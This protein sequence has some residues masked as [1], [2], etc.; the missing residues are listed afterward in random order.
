MMAPSTTTVKK[1]CLTF[2]GI[3]QLTMISTLDWHDLNRTGIRPGGTYSTQPQF[4]A[5]YT[6]IKCK[7]IFSKGRFEQ[8]LEGRLL[9]EYEKNSTATD[10][11]R[12]TAVNNPGTA[13]GTRASITAE[14]INNGMG[15]SKRIA[16]TTI[17]CNC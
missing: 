2:P 13:N 17:R 7:N 15:R 10:A 5:T 1:L 8:D 3:N 14:D 16:G 12:A 6:A 9:I 11:G 4:N